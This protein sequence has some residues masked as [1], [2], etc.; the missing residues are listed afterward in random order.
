MSVRWFTKAGLLVVLPVPN[1]LNISNSIRSGNKQTNKNFGSV[2][3]A[4]K[5]TMDNLIFI[6]T[7]ALAEIKFLLRLPKQ[8]NPSRLPNA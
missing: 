1:E 4:C 7:G 2:S 8:E 3:P 5:A 6:Q